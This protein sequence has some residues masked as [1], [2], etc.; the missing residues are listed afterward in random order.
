MITARFYAIAIGIFV[1]ALGAGAT[2]MAI[3][4]AKYTVVKSD[5]PYEIRDYPSSVVAIVAVNG[6][7]EDAVNAGFRLLANYIFGNNQQKSKIAMTAPVTQIAK[8][9]APVRM[10]MQEA[11]VPD[12][13]VIRFMMPTGYTLQSLPAPI[14]NRVRFEQTDAHRVAVISFSGFWSDTNL[15][16][17]KR[18][19]LEWMQIQHLTPQSAPTYAYYDP[20]WTP[21]FMRTIEVL[22]DIAPA[23]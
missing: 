14:D 13:W 20:P 4:R 5:R 8:S 12:A 1:L 9:T 11:A 7:R 10:L 18:Q 23:G 21:W 6:S 3:E 22:F 19:L 17:H 15:E 16:S 2:C